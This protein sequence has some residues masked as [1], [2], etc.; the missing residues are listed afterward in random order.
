MLNCAFGVGKGKWIKS[1][2]KGCEV[3]IPGLIINRVPSNDLQV[4]IGGDVATLPHFGQWHGLE[5]LDDEMLVWGPGEIQCAF[6][7]FSL[8]NDWLPWFALDYPFLGRWLGL[9]D[10]EPQHVVACVVLMGWL[11]AVG[12]A[13]HSCGG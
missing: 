7:V 3:E 13:K 12:V 4:P 6:Y 10:D 1:A 8:P 9:D 5:V 2:S 11:S